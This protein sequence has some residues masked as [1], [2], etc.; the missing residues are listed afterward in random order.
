MFGGV[1]GGA[2]GKLKGKVEAGNWLWRRVEKDGRPARLLR[3]ARWWRVRRRRR[4]MSRRWNKAAWWALLLLRKMLWRS[5]SNFR[6]YSN[7]VL[8][9]HDGVEYVIRG[10]GYGRSEGRRRAKAQVAARLAAAVRESRGRQQRGAPLFHRV[11]TGL[12]FSTYCIY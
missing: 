4:E 1:V 12:F 3:A 8:V 11:H 9:D 6:L 2:A 7:V 5:E 10:V